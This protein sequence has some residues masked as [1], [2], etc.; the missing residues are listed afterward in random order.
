LGE[1]KEVDIGLEKYAE[2]YPRLLDQALAF[3]HFD[4]SKSI[5]PLAVKR[6]EN[7]ARWGSS[8]TMRT[9]FTFK[10]DRYFQEPLI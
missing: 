10:T 8:D 7:S 2:H 4:R 1:V 6:D 9:S 3:Q 5:N